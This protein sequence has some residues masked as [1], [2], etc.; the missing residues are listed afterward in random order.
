MQS[1]EHCNVDTEAVE[2]E[3]KT[4][5]RHDERRAHDVPA[6]EVSSAHAWT[7]AARAASVSPF[8]DVIVPTAP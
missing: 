6:V 4:E 8:W 2:A 3:A 1:L 5:Q 7:L